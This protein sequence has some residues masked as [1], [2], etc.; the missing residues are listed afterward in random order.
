MRKRIGFA[1]ALAFILSASAAQAA[2]A[3]SAHPR[4]HRQYRPTSRTESRPHA[5]TQPQPEQSLLP[6]LT[7]Y[8]RS[9]EGNNNGLS[10]N[11]DD[12]ATGCIGGNAD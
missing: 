9:G 3:G 1:L 4:H 5:A 7:P 11:P 6:S 12:C 8:A 10:R 2:E